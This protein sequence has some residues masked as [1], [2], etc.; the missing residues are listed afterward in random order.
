[1]VVEDDSKSFVTQRKIPRL[2]L[3]QPELTSDAMILHFPGQSP[4]QV[5]L[6]QTNVTEKH[7][8]VS[9]WED[10]V[11]AFDLGDEAAGWIHEALLEKRSES[12]PR[13]RLVRFDESEQRMIDEKYRKNESETVL[14]SDGFP[15][16]LASSESLQQLNDWIGNS[17]APLPMNRF[18][19]NFEVSG[20]RSPFGE[21]SWE[22]IRINSSVFR[23]SKPCSRCVIPTIDQ[24]TGIRSSTEPTKTLRKKRY[25]DKKD[26]VYFA[27]NLVLEVSSCDKSHEIQGIISVGDQ[28]EILGT[29]PWFSS[30]KHRIK[31]ST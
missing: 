9:V 31:S 16:L 22:Q 10:R 19:P 29:Y 17:Q 27:Q 7:V 5:S 25:L 24:T 12:K 26:A 20:W 1:M 13:F 21:D 4:L 28:V 15:F 18:R 8:K 3:I 23:V 6:S 14:F 11:W 2:A 30:Y